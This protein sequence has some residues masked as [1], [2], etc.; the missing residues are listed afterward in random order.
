MF[1]KNKSKRFFI[2]NFN[3]ILL[4]L[5]CLSSFSQNF[6]CGTTIPKELIEKE[7]KAMYSSARN[8]N[9]EKCINKTF[10][11]SVHIVLDSLENTNFSFVALQN[12]I[13]QMNEAFAP[14]CF[15]FKVCSTDTIE[16]YQ[17]DRL[18]KGMKE[19]TDMYT[20]YQTPNTINM[21]FVHKINNLGGAGICGFAYFPGGV[22]AVVIQKDCINGNVFI[23]EMGHFFGLY[24]THETEFDII[25][26]DPALVDGSNCPTTGDLICDT[27]VDPDGTNDQNCKYVENDKDSNG[28]YYTPPIGN[29][30]SYYDD[31]CACEFTQGQYNRMID[32]YLS[33]RTNLW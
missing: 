32:Q 20:L 12:A 8:P 5:W 31:V 33:G 27:E 11:I 25:N 4:L 9:P 3:T 15:Q 28:D 30:M 17:Y 1:N 10:S 14:I 16:N 7:K 13:D 19:E 22:E 29:Y 6:N 18:D 2:T 26:N 23:H 24:H 21:Y